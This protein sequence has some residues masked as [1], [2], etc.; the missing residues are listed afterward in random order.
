MSVYN[1]E[2]V[3]K[4]GTAFCLLNH[5]KGQHTQPFLAYERL[6]DQQNVL[7]RGHVSDND[8]SDDEFISSAKRTELLPFLGH[9]STF[10]II[11]L[12]L[13]R[14]PKTPK[15]PKAPSYCNAM[16]MDYIANIKLVTD[17]TKSAITDNLPFSMVDSKAFHH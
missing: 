1:K 7:P 15:T 6:N 2:V 4:S 14:I 9:I 17:V 8:S 13:P 5:I 3:S 11:C 16:A 12:C 10:Y